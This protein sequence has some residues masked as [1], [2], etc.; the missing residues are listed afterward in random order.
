MTLTTG[1]RGVLACRWN[2]S[3]T[4][5]VAEHTEHEYKVLNRW[6]VQHKAH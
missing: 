1:G 4:A 2:G 6:K 5:V 3:L